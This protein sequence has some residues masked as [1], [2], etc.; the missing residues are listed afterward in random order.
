VGCLERRGKQPS[1]AVATVICGQPTKLEFVINLKAAK[2]LGPLPGAKRIVRPI[3]RE[4]V[5]S[6]PGPSCIEHAPPVP[7]MSVHAVAV[8]LLLGGHWERRRL[9]DAASSPLINPRF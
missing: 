6:N 3:S 4:A 2:A 5:P 1:N 7:K 9:D 8:S